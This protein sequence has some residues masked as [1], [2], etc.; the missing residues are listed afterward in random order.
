MTSGSTGSGDGTVNFTAA[1][2][3]VTTARTGTLTIAEQTVTVTDN[4]LPTITCPANMTVDTINLGGTTV[5]YAYVQGANEFLYDT[6]VVTQRTGPI[7]T[8]ASVVRERAGDDRCERYSDVRRAR[9]Q[10]AGRR[11]PAS[12]SSSP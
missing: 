3:P 4:Q 1:L 9:D 6:D 7:L 12:S 8:L 11:R 2:N 5:S 10:R